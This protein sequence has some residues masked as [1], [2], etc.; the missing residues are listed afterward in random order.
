MPRLTKVYRTLWGLSGNPFPDHAIA[1]AGDEEQPFYDQLHPGIVAKMA[2]A[3]VGINGA[4]PRVGFL[5]SLG[6][7]EEARGY[8]KTRH[9]LW[10]AGRVN[11]DF[12]KRVAKLAGREEAE[13]LLAAYAAFSTVEGLSLSNLLFDMALNLVRSQADRLQALRSE[14]FKK[15]KTS[16]DIY[17]GAAKRLRRSEE[18][19]SPGLLR[20]LCSYE[21][22]DWVAYLE[23]FYQWHK[24]RYGRQMLRSA[25][26]FLN[27]VGVDRLLVLVDQVEDF[28]SYHTPTYKLQRDFARLAL[29]CRE[30]RALRN[31]VTFVLTMHPRASLILS[32]YWS[33][34]DLGPI[35][36]SEDADNVVMLGAMPKA[37]FTSLVRT[38]LDA[39]RVEPCPDPL[40]PFT[41]TTIA[42][43]HEHERGRPGFCLQKLF[44][45]ME[46]AAAERIEYIEPSVAETFLADEGSR[47]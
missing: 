22:A 14:E 35:S 27:E 38:Y 11:E 39:V 15:G 31:R 9:L 5:W 17:E 32:R 20:S 19:W 36:V 43:I 4:V 1:S 26:A 2:R 6:Y 29:L 34:A 8:G 37:R 3:F 10:F 41:E 24:V 44:F 21:P 25:V 18:D 13:R 16:D 40:K 42:Y 46:H 45:L 7:G 47:E 33:E 12:G 28:A 23:G 30:D